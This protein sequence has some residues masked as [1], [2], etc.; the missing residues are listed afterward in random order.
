MGVVRILVGSRWPLLRLSLEAV[1]DGVD[2]M[3]VVGAA[4]DWGDMLDQVRLQAPDAAVVGCLLAGQRDTVLAL[5]KIERRR[6]CRVVVVGPS[7]PPAPVWWMLVAGVSGYVTLDQ[8]PD[9]I[10]RAARVA[11]SGSRV[12]SAEV[13]PMAAALSWGEKPSWASLSTRELDIMRLVAQG[14]EDDAVARRIGVTPLTVRKHVARAMRKLGS[15]DR[16]EMVARLF[17]AGVLDA[18]DLRGVVTAA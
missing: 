4:G 12:F 7:D 17:A 14:L 3:R 1:F 10:V 13:T 9:E 6:K 18:T 16:A 11:A 5:R 15:T 2:G 8:P